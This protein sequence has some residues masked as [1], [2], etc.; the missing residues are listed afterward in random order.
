MHVGAEHVDAEV[1]RVPDE[2]REHEY[3]DAR[4][5]V[6][7]HRA[8]LVEDRGD[9]ARRKAEREQSRI[10][11]DVAQIA[12][13]AVQA[14]QALQKPLERASGFAARRQ[15]DA[16]GADA[17]CDRAGRAHRGG[18]REA[19][20]DHVGE[21]LHREQI[22]DAAADKHVPEDDVENRILPQPLPRKLV[23]LRAE[24]G[25]Q[26]DD[27]DEEREQEQPHRL[28]ERREPQRRDRDID[29]EERLSDDGHGVAEE[30]A[31]HRAPENR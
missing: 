1:Q 31:E 8:H 6:A 15:H 2:E 9:D 29:V 26:V 28:V 18:Q 17:G 10:G 30:A 19:E 12:R 5:A 25:E 16:D 4:R 21:H 24:A 23:K 22:E 3:G 27:A 11:E 20:R 13:H 7:E 14:V